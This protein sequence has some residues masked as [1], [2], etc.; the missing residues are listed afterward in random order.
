MTANDPARPGPYYHGTWAD[1]AP[2]DLIAPG[3]HPRGAQPASY[4]PATSE[5]ITYFE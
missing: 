4:A 3:F 5:R 2:G 1:L